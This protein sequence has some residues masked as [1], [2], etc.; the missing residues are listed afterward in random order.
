MKAKLSEIDKHSK[1]CFHGK[2]IPINPIAPPCCCGHIKLC[3]GECEPI[4]PCCKQPEKN[5]ASP[6]FESTRS[7]VELSHN[8]LRQSVCIKSRTNKPSQCSAYYGGKENEVNSDKLHEVHFTQENFRNLQEV[9]RELRRQVKEITQQKIH[10]RHKLDHTDKQLNILIGKATN[11]EKIDRSKIQELI[12]YIESQRDI[13]KNSV[14]RL[15]NKLDPNRVSKLA[16]DIEST[17]S[18]CN[19]DRQ[20]YVKKPPKAILKSNSNNIRKYPYY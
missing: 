17:T 11:S 14:E 15:L 9:N 1:M 3:R 20:Y 19:I 18:D 6:N 16:R 8:H 12:T 13:Y 10:L 2:V 4:K 7:M 5:N